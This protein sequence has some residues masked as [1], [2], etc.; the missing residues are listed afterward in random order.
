VCSWPAM[1]VLVS[2]HHLQRLLEPFASIFSSLSSV[3]L[4]VRERRMCCLKTSSDTTHAL[5]VTIPLVENMCSS[6]PLDLKVSAPRL[7]SC[8]V[9]FEGDEVLRLRVDESRLLHLER[10]LAESAAHCAVQVR[11]RDATTL[12][13]DSHCMKLYE[14]PSALLMPLG[15]LTSL[16]SFAQAADSLHAHYCSVTMSGHGLA[17]RSDG[18]EV[19]LALDLGCLLQEVV[20]DTASTT[21]PCSL[22]LDLASVLEGHVGAAVASW[23]LSL[24]SRSDACEVDVALFRT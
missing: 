10:A 4:L 20:N 2:T 13:D 5:R 22:L 23:G 19:S 8:L 18:D 21:V 11:A 3:T 14:T 6:K 16:I 9:A 12:S 17:L 15:A 1:D 24:R 7:L